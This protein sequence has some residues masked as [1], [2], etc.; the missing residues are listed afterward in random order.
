MTIIEERLAEDGEV[1]ACVALDSIGDAVDD[2]A[3]SYRSNASDA[4]TATPKPSYRGVA[5]VRPPMPRI[6]VPPPAGLL[7]STIDSFGG[8]GGKALAAAKATLN[9]AAAADAVAAAAIDGGAAGKAA[10]CPAAGTLSTS[11]S[12]V[13]GAPA[14]M[15]AVPAVG[16]SDTAR[17][18]EA[19]LE[20]GT[21]FR[22][23]KFEQRLVDT[24]PAP[25]PNG[26][27]VG[28]AGAGAGGSGGGGGGSG[29]VGT[30]FLSEGGGGGGSYRSRPPLSA[31]F[32]PLPG[33][34]GSGSGG[35]G[36]S[37]ALTPSPGAASPPARQT[38][39]VTL[40]KNGQ[41]LVSSR[42]QLGPGSRR[43]YMQQWARRKAN[44]RAMA[45]A[46]SGSGTKAAESSRMPTLQELEADPSGIAFAFGGMEP[47][48]LHAHGQLHEVHKVSYSIG[49]AGQYLLH[50]RMR[51]AAASLPGSPFV[52]SVVPASAYA[53]ST[54]LP[55]EP[56][57][58]MVGNA[59]GDGCECE[60]RT[61]D[62]MGNYCIVGGASLS[63][64]TGIEAGD[65]RKA[66]K[67]GGAARTD[68]REAAIETEVV[69]QGNG[70]YTLRWRCKYSGT[71]R[72]R[73]LVD[74]EDV[75]GS[76]TVFSLTSST[77]DLSKTVLAGDGLRSATAGRPSTM[78]ISFVDQF[79]N[80]AV[81]DARFA[82]GLA[83]VTRHGGE[84]DKVAN[85]PA[86]GFEGEWEGGA[87]GVFE[88]R[89]TPTQAGNADL[90]VWCDPE[91]KGERLAFPGS[92][93]Q[94]HIVEGPA[95]AAASVVDG[96]AKV[97][98]EDKND[99]YGKD[100]NAEPSVLLASDTVSIRPLIYDQ[101][102]NGAALPEEALAIVHHLPSGERHSLGYTQTSKGGS[103]SYDIRHDLAM[104][105][106][107]A[108]HILL[109][110]TPIRGSPVTFTVQPSK[111]DPGCCKLLSPEDAILWTDRS[112]RFTLKTYDRFGNECKL[113]G[114]TIS[115]RLQL[116]K[117]SARDQTSL[118]PSNHSMTWDD[119][120]DGTYTVLL[121][122]NIPCTVKL[123]V[124]VDKNLQA[125]AGELPP[126][127]LT[128]QDSS[129]AAEERPA[130]LAPA[131]K[132]GSTKKLLSTSAVAGEA[133]G[134]KNSEGTDELADA[135]AREGESAGAL[136]D[137]AEDGDMG[138]GSPLR[139]SPSAQRH[140]LL[141]GDGTAD[142]RPNEVA[143][144]E[145]V[146]SFNNWLTALV[147]GSET[148]ADTIT[149]SA[150]LSPDPLATRPAL[151]TG[152]APSSAA[153]PAAAIKHAET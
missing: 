3:S 82:F 26:G 14:P 65:A 29:H 123:I 110:N 134:S 120:A 57:R 151:E 90:H 22:R 64:V 83:V 116:V 69:D 70:A 114:L 1:R 119:N 8:L 103:T 35:G 142:K 86:H 11:E 28:G 15:P 55:A 81:P 104:A 38:G 67:A 77:P 108:V 23:A 16:V 78:Q 128:F 102:G 54:R 93:F 2:A 106:E 118:V 105:G 113:G 140:R 130:K 85:V 24:E 109:Y 52:L 36:L 149:P 126:L 107:H 5:P 33:G 31:S 89:Y 96:W 125:G 56:L 66:G 68:E 61:A 30:V 136:S 124:N 144:A 80:T 50:V 17:S 153:A 75:Q 40:V 88:L 139:R 112:Y 133:T 138:G 48:T 87:S 127:S 43:Q 12:A 135:G 121:T 71:F 27:A 73:V 60:L 131:L 97:H 32:M 148:I 132:R 6:G 20:E 18:R 129:A 117:Q 42:V 59:E 37:G 47:G 19:A 111:P 62:K 51:Q 137:A 122:L 91:G 150:L 13:E 95:S 146:P 46:P 152:A 76:P 84:R 34:D 49:L 39:W 41:K 7:S 141:S 9:A 98:K 72:T 100:K 115:N 63:I 25:A 79:L 10:G 99:K 74:G 101:F 147:D 143:L 45:A 92:P 44:D 4:A 94:L 145:D 53:K 58:G 21:D